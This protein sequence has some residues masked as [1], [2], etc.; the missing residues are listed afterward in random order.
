MGTRIAAALVALSVVAGGC[1][2]DP[3][4]PPVRSEPSPQPTARTS[5]T[6]AAAVQ[7][8][9]LAINVHRPAADIGRPLARRIIAGEPVRWADL[10]QDGGPV[11][12]RRGPEALDAVARDLAVLAV[13]PASILRP[14]VQPVSVDGVDPLRSP[15]RYPL[16][17]AADQPV[18]EVTTV[19]V[20][21]DIMLGRGVGDRHAADPG[22]PL[23]PLADRL[24]SAELTVGNLE[25]TLSDDG[26]PRQGDDSFAADPA[27]VGALAAA[28]FDVLSLANNHTGD[29]GDAAFRDTLRRLDHSPIRRVGAGVDADAAWRPVVVRR[30]GMRIGFV[31]FNAIGETPRATASQPG[32]AEVRMQPRT[33]PLNPGDLRRLTSTIEDLTERADIVI[34]LPHW[35]DQYTNQP[36]QDQ[37]RVGRAMLHAGADIVVGGHPHW[38]QGIQTHRDG[39][40]VHSLGNF[41][42][43]MD[44]SQATEEGVLLELVW[45]GS[46][47]MGARFVPYVID[48]HYLPRLAYGPRAEA[49]LERMWAASDPPFG[50]L[51]G[52]A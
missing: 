18:G 30:D 5:E 17:T 41:V 4:D 15:H 39:L 11:R 22:R 27:V 33:G 34:G 24:R 12:V 21:G 2:D 43:D 35:G 7:P 42:F 31:A 32:A 6:P 37:R 3:D 40:V 1:S 13:V 14:T 45:W 46:E 51:G 49:T 8:L 16:T 23:R 47:L 25:S 38:V 52:A 36:V 44:F 9:A 48:D 26:V 10:G 19:T 20:V 29:Y 50:R 28:G